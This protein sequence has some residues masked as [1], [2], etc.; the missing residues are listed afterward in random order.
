M[1]AYGAGCGAAIERQ[2]RKRKIIITK[3]I[4][5]IYAS[6][7]GIILSLLYLPIYLIYAR[8]RFHPPTV[9]R[10][11]LSPFSRRL[12]QRW[13]CAYILLLLL[14]LL[15]YIVLHAR[16]VYVRFI[17]ERT[18]PRASPTTPKYEINTRAFAVWL[19]IRPVRFNGGVEKVF[20]RS[21]AEIVSFTIHTG[22][23]IF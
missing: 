13:W 12:Q 2:T 11:S 16:L 19:F 22:Y 3:K 23:N 18:P 4:I 7:T 8:P 21:S 15:Y 1:S 5:N 20:S 17:A 10:Y 14:L 9:Y 6:H